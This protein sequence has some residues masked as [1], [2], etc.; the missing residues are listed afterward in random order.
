MPESSLCTSEVPSKD[1]ASA[2][3]V[4]LKNECECTVAA[5]FGFQKL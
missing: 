4:T 5:A 3:H 2:L 1:A